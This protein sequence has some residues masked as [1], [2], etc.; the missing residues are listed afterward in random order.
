MFVKFIYVLDHRTGYVCCLQLAN[1]RLPILPYPFFLHFIQSI[2]PLPW[3]KNSYC[4]PEPSRRLQSICRTW[5]WWWGRGQCRGSTGSTWSKMHDFSASGPGTTISI[6]KT[7]SIITVITFVF[8]PSF[9]L[10][11]TM[12]KSLPLQRSEW[13]PRSMRTTAEPQIW[14]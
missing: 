10:F 11:L 13:H 12:W 9:F 7:A 14:D 6:I 5:L 3:C 4:L 8:R 1:R 2:T